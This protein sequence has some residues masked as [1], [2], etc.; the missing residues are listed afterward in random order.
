[1]KKSIRFSLLFA[2]VLAFLLSFPVYAL[3][4]E[5]R[6]VG[7]GHI[8]GRIRRE[9]N[10]YVVTAEAYA[11]VSRIDVSGTLYEDGWIWDTKVGSCSN[12]SSNT[13]CTA[14]GSYTFDNSKSY[15][16]EYSDTFYYSD[17]TSETV[18]GSTTG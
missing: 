17:G 16:L 12:S 3:G 6:Y 4:I 2:I 5:S 14:S 9:S 7:D 13:S 11:S 15:R 10:S 18:S 1:M 8:Q